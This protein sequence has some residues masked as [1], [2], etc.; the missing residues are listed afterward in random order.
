M[1][2]EARELGVVEITI[3][4]PG[5]R[6]ERLMERLHLYSAIQNGV[7]IV[8]GDEIAFTRFMEHYSSRLYHYTFALLGQKE[9]AEEIVSDVFFEVW[10]N[11][12]SLAE[13]GN[14]NAWIQTIT[15][16][17]AI[18]FLRKETGKY[19]LSF[20][21]IE[22]FIFEPVQSPAEEMISKEEMAKINDAIQQLPPKCKHVFFLAKI[23]GLPYKDIADMLNISVKTIN[24]HI[25]FALDEI[26]KRL[27]LKSRKS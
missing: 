27:N 16:R 19:E 3:H 6:A 13:I 23:D 12:K 9:S 18:S 11:R 5:A 7:L 20:D 26:A 24:N 2:S 10:K 15:Y 17:K 22:D 21:D 8:D 25:A 4:E 1:L 14:M